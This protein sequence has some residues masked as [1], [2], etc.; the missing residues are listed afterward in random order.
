MARHG[1]QWSSLPEASGLGLCKW[2]KLESGGRRGLEQ[3]H[4][5]LGLDPSNPHEW[6]SSGQTGGSLD[7]P[8]SEPSQLANPRSS[9]R[10]CLKEYS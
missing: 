5:N 3:K 7:F 6:H 4:E 9:E 2:K 10:L 1:P 8:A